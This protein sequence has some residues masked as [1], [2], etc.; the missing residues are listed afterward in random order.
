MGS[1]VVVSLTPE[2]IA[3]VDGVMDEARHAALAGKPGMAVA[4]IFVDHMRVGFLP[5]E[6]AEPIATRLA[7]GSLGRCR[8]AADFSEPTDNEREAHATASGPHQDPRTDKHES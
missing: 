2:Q 8:T 7:D 6:R 4:Q 3:A 5:A 1:I